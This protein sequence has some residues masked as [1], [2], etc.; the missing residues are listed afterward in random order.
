MFRFVYVYSHVSHFLFRLYNVP[1]GG[2]APW[3]SR[4]LEFDKS[5]TSAKVSYYGFENY[6]G[7]VKSSEIVQI[8][9]DSKEPIG[10]LISFTLKTQSI[11]EFQSFGKAIKE[12]Q[13]AMG[14]DFES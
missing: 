1:Q 8:D 5:K 3:P 14:F 9:N 10:N 6:T 7:S 11:R 13:G 2:Y 4:I 12:I